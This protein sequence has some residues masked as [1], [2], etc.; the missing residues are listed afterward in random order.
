MN[1]NNGNDV[2]LTKNDIA[3]LDHACTTLTIAC[4][5]AINKKCVYLSVLYDRMKKCHIALVVCYRPN[6]KSIN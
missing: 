1:K 6:E 3:V 4:V 5:L 2:C